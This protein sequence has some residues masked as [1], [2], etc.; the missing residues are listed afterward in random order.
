MFVFLASDLPLVPL[1]PLEAA[2]A[3]ASP[4][5]DLQHQMCQTKGTSTDSVGLSTED[6]PGF[7]KIPV[8][9]F[10]LQ[11]PLQIEVAVAVWLN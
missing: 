2:S 11:I 1:V 8:F 10:Q 6:S 3:V 5:S 9:F 4:P 7:I